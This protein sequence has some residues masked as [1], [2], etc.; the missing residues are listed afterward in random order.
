MS[1]GRFGRNETPNAGIT[2]ECARNAGSAL[3]VTPHFHSLVPDRVFVPGEGVV[4]F[5]PLPPPTQAEVERL[6]RVHSTGCC[7][8]SGFT[9]VAAYKLA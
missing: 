6:L 4:R 7:A 8:C 5:E 1:A 3:Q 9:H 2:G